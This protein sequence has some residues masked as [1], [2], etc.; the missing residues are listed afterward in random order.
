MSTENT[1]SEIRYGKTFR[2]FIGGVFVILGII[3]ALLPILPGWLCFLIAFVLLFP[4]H[5]RVVKLIAKA[6]KKHPKWVKWLHAFGIG[7]VSEEET[8][9]RETECQ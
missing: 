9:T 3:G 7:D 5:P 4:E 6:E 8:A 2:I 1:G